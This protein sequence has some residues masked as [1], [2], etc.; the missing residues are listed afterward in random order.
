MTPSERLREDPL[1]HPLVEREGILHLEPAPAFFPRFVT[2][3]VRQQ[4]SMAAATAIE[5]R[6]RAVC[7]LTPEDVLAADPTEFREAGLSERKVATIH[8]VAE[9]F[10]DERWSRARFAELTD[11]SVLDE[12]TTAPGVGVWTAKMQLMFSLGRPDVFPVEDLGIRRAVRTLVG[13]DDLT[14]AE[15]ATLAER[16]APERSLAALYLWRTGD[17]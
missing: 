12:L 15:I 3:I 13:D 1:L 16:W 11:R 2:S 4:I 7:A 8:G 14:R 6:L 9:R 17:E 5:D 10:A